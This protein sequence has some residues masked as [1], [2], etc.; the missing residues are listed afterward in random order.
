MVLHNTSR[1]A[2]RKMDS[3]EQRN[4]RQAQDKNSRPAALSILLEIDRNLLRLIARRAQLLRE[5]P[6]SRSSRLER[7]L[8]AGW[9]AAASKISR[10]PRLV[11]QLFAL[12]QE[13]ECLP[14]LQENTVG[15]QD[16]F[17]LTPVRRPVNYTMTCPL[18]C[19]RTRILGALAAITGSPLELHSVRI[20]DPLVSLVKGFNQLGPSLRWEEDGRLLCLPERGPA[21]GTD[22]ALLDRAMH[23]GGDMLN[24]LLLLFSVAVRPCRLKIMGESA[25]KLADLSPLRRF[26][27]AIGAR[28][29]PIIPGQD[30]LP[31]RLEASGLLPERVIVPAEIGT[32]AILALC[33]GLACAPRSQEIEVHL[34]AHPAAASVLEEVMSILGLVGAAPYRNNASLRFAATDKPVLNMPDS[35]NLTMDLAIAVTMLVF[36][37]L[38]GGT[39]KVI[40]VW[41]SGRTGDAAWKL[42]VAAGLK[43][44][45]E[46]QHIVAMRQ[47]GAAEFGDGLNDAV[48]ADLDDDLLPLVTALAA[49]AAIRSDQAHLPECVARADMA[50]VD[51][52]LEHLGVKRDGWQLRP[53][54][55]TPAPWSSPSCT[56]AVALAL[57]AFA[58]PGLKL[59]NPGIVTERMP[60]FWQWYNS[61]PSPTMI[62]TPAAAEPET[63]AH[64]MRRRILANHM[65]EDQF[66]VPLST[67]ES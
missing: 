31:A 21:I 53:G 8:R 30:G 24:F 50:V 47:E 32:D 1:P 7:E 51:D 22:K 26:L 23:I 4:S 67:A 38:I 33:L 28:F 2:S 52:F 34:D 6:Q 9:E 19:R 46:E 56:W 15:R 54:S 49:Q 41:P 37:A 25:L 3:G 5:L 48:C 11:R 14:L 12:L 36:P 61:L 20:N 60:G 40:G 66:P 10:D 42:L 16:A 43:L 13:V 39:A 55:G 29:T 18:D 27:P 44:R 58:R 65:P 17:T 45:R 35:K 63:K 64:P 62:R 59:L 57:A